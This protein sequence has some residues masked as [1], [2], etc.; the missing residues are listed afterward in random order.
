[1]C[2][3]CTFS[4]E[5]LD[6]STLYVSSAL[7]HLPLECL[8]SVYSGVRKANLELG[9]VGPRD[10]IILFPLY[11]RPLALESRYQAAGPPAAIVSASA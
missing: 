2:T 7:R 1:M 4:R 5:F 11:S 6:H 10:T 9:D 3:E 8:A